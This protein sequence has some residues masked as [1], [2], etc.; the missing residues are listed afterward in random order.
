VLADFADSMESSSKEV[1]TSLT[2]WPGWQGFPV[3]ACQ[4]KQQTPSFRAVSPITTLVAFNHRVNPSAICNP[5]HCYVLRAGSVREVGI[6]V[7]GEVGEAV[8]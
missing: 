4:A 5:L 6:E 3:V 8:Q 2:V 1:V 7:G